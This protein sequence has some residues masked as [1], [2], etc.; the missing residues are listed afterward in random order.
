V[1]GG[2]RGRHLHLKPAEG[3][4]LYTDGITEAR[5]H[6]HQQLGEERLAHAL[7]RELGETYTA[8]QVI[9]VVTSVV[10]AFAGGTD[11][12]DN[13]AALALTAVREKEG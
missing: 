4:L 7:S 9:D 12:G 6:D 3:L 11:P 8:Q 5:N 13:Q 1:H 10:S 2:H